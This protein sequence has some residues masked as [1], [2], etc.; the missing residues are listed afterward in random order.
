MTFDVLVEGVSTA[1]EKFHY[2][3]SAVITIILT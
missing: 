1:A 2:D 3:L